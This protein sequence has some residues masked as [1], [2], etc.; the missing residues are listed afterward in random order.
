MG[1]LFAHLARR[2]ADPIIILL[3]EL[4][5]SWGFCSVCVGDDE[6]WGVDSPFQVRVDGGDVI[7]AVYSSVKH[8]TCTISSWND[9]GVFDLGD[10]GCFDLLRDCLFSKVRQAS[11]KFDN[12]FQGGNRARS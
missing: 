6:I 1:N 3:G 4:I 7:V 9:A 12:S 8:P 10:P 2:S 11:A 5:R